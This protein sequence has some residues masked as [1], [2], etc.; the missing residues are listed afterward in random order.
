MVLTDMRAAVRR[1]L[2]DEDSATCRWADNEIDRAIDRA[3]SVFSTYSPCK[4]KSTVA[5]VNGSRIIDVSALKPRFSIDLVEFPAGNYPPVFV[6][7]ALYMDS[8]TLSVPGTGADC[9]MY[10]TTAHSVTAIASTLPAQYDWLITLG[11][12]AFAVLAWSQY[13]TNRANTGGD[14]VDRDYLYWARGRELEFIKEC[15]R[16][17]RQ[18]IMREMYHAAD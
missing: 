13:S 15:K 9:S 8:L 3:V 2:K 6:D 7:F 5:T 18:L 1:D 11:A 16:L 17:R 4:A 10:W 14:G 12:S